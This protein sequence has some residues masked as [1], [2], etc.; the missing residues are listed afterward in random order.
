MVSGQAQGTSPEGGTPWS[1]RVR[2]SG[3][4]RRCRTPPRGTFRG[5]SPGG[6]S[7]HSV[8]INGILDE[9]MLGRIGRMMLL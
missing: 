4:F 1:S 7:S 9:K 8:T 3:T 2:K 6:T 5:R